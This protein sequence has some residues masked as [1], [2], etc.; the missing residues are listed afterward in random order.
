MFLL[1]HRS[2]G[3]ISEACALSV[4]GKRMCQLEGQ[5]EDSPYSVIMSE[6]ET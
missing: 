4:G 1:L 3:S 2:L 5:G 6:G